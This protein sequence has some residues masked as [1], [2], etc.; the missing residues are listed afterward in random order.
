MN[1]NL[2]STILFYHSAIY[3]LI[4]KQHIVISY[5]MCYTIVQNVIFYGVYE[6]KYKFEENVKSVTQW[7]SG[8]L[9]GADTRENRKSK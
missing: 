1:Q 3:I 4:F 5:R 9:S 7:K 8:S 6:V 2:N